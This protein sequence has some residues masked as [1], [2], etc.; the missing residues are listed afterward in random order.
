MRDVASSVALL[1]PPGRRAVPQQPGAPAGVS[2]GSYRIGHRAASGPP[3]GTPFFTSVPD[4]EPEAA[5]DAI[6]HFEPKRCRVPLFAGAMPGAG[7]HKVLSE[8][9]SP[10]IDRQRRPPLPR[11]SSGRALHTFLVRLEGDK[12]WSVS[13]SSAQ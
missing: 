9:T 1:L 11:N 8:P 5:S 13:H 2:R 3:Y 6:R 12:G 4:R 7:P 10:I